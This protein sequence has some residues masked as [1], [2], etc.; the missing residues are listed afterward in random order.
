MA[1][2]TT[3][4]DRIQ[5]VVNSA[6][7]AISLAV[8]QNIAAEIQRL[9]GLPASNGA[10]DGADQGAGRDR[11]RRDGEGA[12]EAARSGDG[13]DQGAE[14][15]DDLQRGVADNTGSVPLAWSAPLADDSDEALCLGVGSHQIYY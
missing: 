3:L 6:A 2:T 10:P 14:A 1:N 5:E 8:R 9:V 12:R 15:G 4:E 13:E 11:R 7:E